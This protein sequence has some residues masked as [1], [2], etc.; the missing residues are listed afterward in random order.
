MKKEIYIKLKYQI[1]E[2]YDNTPF[3]PLSKEKYVEYINGLIKK[4]Q[5]KD[6]NDLIDKIKNYT[7]S[8]IMNSS[9]YLDFVDYYINQNY[10][11]TLN[12]NKILDYF[13]DLE[14]FFD[15]CKEMININELINLLK[16]NKKI[17]SL[18]EVAF[19]Y[20]EKNII[21]NRIN[22]STDCRI[23]ISFIEAYCLINNIEIKEENILNY[24]NDIINY[25]TDALENYLRNIKRYK[26]LNRDEER[27]LITRA[28][29]GDDLAKDLIICCNIRLV[30]S[31]VLKHY[32]YREIPELDLIQEGTFGLIKALEK[33]D[34]NTNY[35][36]STYAYSWI[37][38]FIDRF[39][40]TKGRNIYIPIKMQEKIKEYRKKELEFENKYK[41]KPTCEEISNITGYDQSTIQLIEANLSDSISY[42]AQ[43][44]TDEDNSLLDLIP[45]K[46]KT[47]DEIYLEKS[48]KQILFKAIYEAGLTVREKDV[49]QRRFGFNG[50]IQTLESIG[51][52]YGLSRERVRIIEKNAL[53][54]LQKYFKRY[55]WQED[56]N[57]LYSRNIYSYFKDYQEIEV[58]YAIS[59]LPE[60]YKNI[61]YFK[62]GKDLKHYNRLLSMDKERKFY[63][64]ILPKITE[65]LERLYLHNKIKPN[66]K[67][68]SKT[69]EILL[70]LFKMYPFNELIA[71][72]SY[73][74]LLIG[75]LESGYVD[76]IKYTDEI[77]AN[78]LGIDK[79]NARILNIEFKK[80]VY[81]N[82][83]LS[84]IIE[85]RDKYL[86]QA[87]ESFTN[88][89]TKRQ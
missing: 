34:L 50:K 47:P 79:A 12:L 11:F 58:N 48:Q 68:N 71:E 26:V 77:V 74:R 25:D 59:I 88:N 40:L 35:K 2:Y 82:S 5:I 55:V 31:I 83:L 49:I 81:T 63:N 66:N 65:I 84:D 45:D 85:N 43:I 42:D 20:Y 6:N 73:D 53:T 37:K 89:L 18:T 67:V 7:L 1:E 60:E 22:D 39:L 33:Y 27:N 15:N 3:I 24:D 16:N 32:R 80:R 44:N 21:N 76:G 10:S 36:F 17:Y 14:E 62:F 52:I 87:K 70:N 38:Q 61:I 19:K 56:N 75:L 51:N 4:V 9:N 28:K 86:E 57:N 72:I 78:F 69:F 8:L 30:A 23:L 29:Q 13:K 64:E 46:N 41:R 54:K